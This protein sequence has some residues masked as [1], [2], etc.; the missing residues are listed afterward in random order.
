[1]GVSQE[2]KQE[3]ARLLE[4]TG[5]KRKYEEL[6]W[7][8]KQIADDLG[9]T[10]GQVIKALKAAGVPTRSVKESKAQGEAKLRSILTNYERYGTSNPLGKGSPAFEKKQKTVLDRYG[11]D[12]VRK[13][14]E[15]IARMTEVKRVNGSLGNTNPAAISAAFQRR[16]KNLEW[17]AWFS[18]R[19][20]D[21][22]KN[23]YQSLTDEQRALAAANRQVGWQ[24]WWVH[25]SEEE[26]QAFLKKA[27]FVSKLEETFFELVQS[28]LQVT[29]QRQALVP[30]IQYAF[31]GCVDESKILLEVNGTFWHADPRR[32]KA[33]DV[34]RFP[35]GQERTAEYLWERDFRKQQAATEA[36]YSLITF[37]EK[38]IREA[39][40]LELG[41]LQG[42]LNDYSY[43]INQENQPL[44]QAVRP[45]DA[46]AP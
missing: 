13:V 6:G 43:Q 14:P 11:V 7:S 24:K 38:D 16:L 10:A 19:C 9:V 31:D 33:D 37:W 20:S 26:R 5:L 15:V 46:N 36:G 39:P 2:R 34:L 12:N 22:V 28:T 4:P 44:K 1:M 23:T 42:V 18:R 3:L 27:G 40:E 21:T 8:A 41:R 25:L 32:Y 35:D 29:V 45:S 30:G 17:R